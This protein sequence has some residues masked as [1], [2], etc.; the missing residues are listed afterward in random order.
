MIK[1]LKKDIKLRNIEAINDFLIALKDKPMEDIF[2]IIDYI[3]NIEDQEILSKILLNLTY[4]LGELGKNYNLDEKYINFLHQQYFRSDRWVRK[5]ILETLK[6][7]L[8]FNNKVSKKIEEIIYNGLSEE[9]IPSKIIAIEILDLMGK[10]PS[11]FYPR[12]IKLLDSANQK[13]LE[14]LEKIVKKYF[15]NDEELLQILNDDENYKLLNKNSI[16]II[17]I[18]LFQSIESLE[19]FK[20]KIFETNWSR[21][22]KELILNEIRVYEKILRSHL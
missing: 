10:I 3:L 8:Q 22:H 5:E 2:S 1:Q 13:V 6:K 18:T 12:I 15:K 16:R 14:S 4:L 21:K 17:L 20:S 11:Y 7:M 9:Y 19:K